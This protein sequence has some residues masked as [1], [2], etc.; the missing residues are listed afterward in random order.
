[1]A[2]GAAGDP[3]LGEDFR[4]TC[5]RNLQTLAALAKSV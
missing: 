3:R 5:D 2:P 1:L 4:R